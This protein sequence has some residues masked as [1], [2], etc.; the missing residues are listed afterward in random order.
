MLLLP[1]PFLEEKG[2]WHQNC[3]G[4]AVKGCCAPATDL[5]LLDSFFFYRECQ[6][7]LLQNLL[8]II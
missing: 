2:A 7:F 3:A 6:A 1:S 4:E 5:K 8:Q